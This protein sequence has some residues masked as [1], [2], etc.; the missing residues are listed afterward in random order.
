MKCHVNIQLSIK[1]CHILTKKHSPTFPF[2]LSRFPFHFFLLFHC[3]PHYL[4]D[5]LLA[6]RGYTH[7]F[8]VLDCSTR[9]PATYQVRVDLQFWGPCKADLRPR[10]PVYF[11]SSTQRPPPIIRSPRRPGPR[12]CPPGSSSASG[13]SFDSLGE[14]LR[15][16]FGRRSSFLS[17]LLFLIV[18]AALLV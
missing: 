13:A 9:W 5:P 2:F 11:T 12:S 3:V 17:C 6:V 10:L 14:L 1:V 15:R 16:L 18:V 4:I 7:V 8:T